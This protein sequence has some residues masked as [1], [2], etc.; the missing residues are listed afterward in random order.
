MAAPPAT[1]ST[2]GTSRSARIALLTK[3]SS[4]SFRSTMNFLAW[5]SNTAGTQNPE[6]SWHS[7]SAEVSPDLPALSG[8]RN[9]HRCIWRDSQ[10][11][12]T[13]LASFTRF[14]CRPLSARAASVALN[15]I[16]R[17][18]STFLLGVIR[19]CLQAACRGFAEHSEAPS[20]DSAA[21]HAR[22]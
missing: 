5:C 13:T 11:T 17:Y 21:L 14:S 22:S 8:A 2:N 9:L 16:C 6:A 18:L 3:A 7:V 4:S 10:T 20:D 15:R 1:D 19:N 12:L